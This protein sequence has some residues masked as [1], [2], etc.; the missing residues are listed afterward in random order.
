[1]HIA[2]CVVY[3]LSLI[4]L[5]SASTLYHGTTHPKHKEIFRILDHSCIYLLIAGSYTP[6]ALIILEGSLGTKMVIA[7]WTMA[8]FG[9]LLKLLLGNRFT[10]ISVI[11]YLAMGWLG[12]FGLKPLFD[13]VGS[14]ALAL[15]VAGGL[16]YSLGIIFFAWK[17]FRHHHA[18]FHIFV[19]VG[20][21]LHYLA[22]VLYIVP[23]A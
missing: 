11:S 8:A 22:I 14:V 15:V 10:A 3:G 16:A 5:Y 9:I 4:V 1:M 7:V 19:L 2:S 23:A 17:R 13:T 20:S 6:F 21:L 18:I 12:A